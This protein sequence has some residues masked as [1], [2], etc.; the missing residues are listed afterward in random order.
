MIGVLGH[1]SALLRP[2][3]AEDNLGEWDEFYYESCPRRRIDSSTCWPAVHRATTVPWMP[4]VPFDITGM[5][6]Q[7]I[8][9]QY[10]WYS[11]LI[12]KW[13]NDVLDHKILLCKTI[14][15][16]ELPVLMRWILVWIVSQVQ[17]WLFD[18]LDSPV[19]Y[20]CAM[21]PLPHTPPVL[22]LSRNCSDIKKVSVHYLETCINLI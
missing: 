14:P 13:N 15:G 21:T 20:Y 17:D 4:P 16:Q 8:S 3:W 5:R 12:I 19:R 1:N 18:L 6:N 7:P 2:Y 22:S 10:Q 9:S 11:T